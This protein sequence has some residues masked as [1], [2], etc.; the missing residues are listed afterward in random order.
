[1]FYV[2]AGEPFLVKLPYGA[3]EVSALNAI[4]V[5]QDDGFFALSH[6]ETSEAEPK[7]VNLKALCDKYKVPNGD[8]AGKPNYSL[9]G[10]GGVYGDE[11]R[12]LVPTV[13][14]E[15]KE[16]PQEKSIPAWVW[17]VLGGFGAAVVIAGC[18]VVSKVRKIRRGGV[19]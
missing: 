12:V 17:W 11:Y 14:P 3:Y 4:P 6:E 1:V 7:V 9:T 13:E 10:N 16:E 15:Q 5:S 19:L 2:A 18:I 8:I